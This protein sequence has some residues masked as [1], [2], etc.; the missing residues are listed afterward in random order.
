MRRLDYRR[1]LYSWLLLS[2]LMPMIA[3]TALHVHHAEAAPDTECVDCLHHMPHSGH[4]SVQTTN[5]DDCVLCQFAGLNFVL[6][7][8]VLLPVFVNVHRAGVT[9]P[10]LQ[11][12]V[13]YS[14]L[15]DSRAPPFAC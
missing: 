2:V 6:A 13:G 1:R 12:L 10:V 9:R 7:A 5:L 14:G 4:L 3:L 15:Y 11:H 8:V